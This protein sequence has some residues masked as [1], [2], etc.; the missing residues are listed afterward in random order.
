MKRLFVIGNGFDRAHD[1]PTS[2]E[3]FREYVEK[4]DIIFYESI[5]RYIPEE[6]LW[7]DFE[8]ALG[9]LD[10]YELQINNSAYYLDY[11]SDSWR[12]SAH[13]EY[14]MMIKNELSFSQKISEYI[15]M[16]ISTVDTAVFPRISSKLFKESIFLN[17]NYTDTLERVYKILEENILYLHGK[18]KLQDCLI[19]GHH[20]TEI[21]NSHI[22]SIT[23]AEEHGVYLEDDEED[24]R[25]TEAKNIIREYFRETYKDTTK[26]LQEN[27]D[28]F[29]SLSEITEVYILGHSISAIDEDYF[30]E[31]R[32]RVSSDVVWYISYFDE[33]DM[34]RIDSVIEKLNIR[35]HK[36][37][38]ISDLFE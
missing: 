22:V 16:W 28:F 35:N 21:L 20:K 19:I 38:K 6:E 9:E 37:I 15:K 7:S 36:K 4:I 17:F 27:K 25:I 18:A 26:I 5:S 29:D 3:D 11:G 33:L 8:F 14:Q 13:Y 24:I 34:E 30:V 31:I 32:R 2:Y 1:L 10:Y 12:D 23:E